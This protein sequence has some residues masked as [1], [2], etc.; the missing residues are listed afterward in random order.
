MAEVA[1]LP[2]PIALYLHVPFCATRC[3]YCDFN[4]YAGLEAFFEPYV[5]ALCREIRSAGAARGR[6]PA[7]T[8]FI[9]GGTPTVLPADLL[10][11]ALAACREAF[12]VAAAAEITCE[13][14]P[15]HATALRTAAHAGR[16]ASAKPPCG[17][18]GEKLTQRRQD[19]KMARRTQ[20]SL[21]PFAPLREA[22]RAVF[23]TGAHAGRGASAKPPRGTADEKLTQ[24]RQDAEMARRTQR[25]FAPFAP[26]R[27]A[28]G[29][30]FRTVAHAACAAT[31]G[32]NR[33][34]ASIRARPRPVF[35]T[36]TADQPAFALLRQLGVNR[37]SLGVQ[38]FDDDE[39]R[40]LGRIHTSAEATAAFMAARAAGFTNLN[41]D[42]IFGLPG[43]P[44]A[45]WR[46]TLAHAVR[47]QGEHLSLY[48]L[49]LEEGAPLADRVRRGLSPAPDE[50]L[51]AD[52]YLFAAD[53]LAAHGYVQYEISNWARPSQT[54]LADLHAPASDHRC[55]H[56]LTYW[57]REPY[58]GFGAGA[59]SFETASEAAGA[60]RRWW[61][62][63]AVP[64]YIQRMNT[65]G[66]AEAGHETI[67][68]RLAMGEMM[69]LGL[70]LTAEGVSDAR[71]RERFGVEMAE[72]FGQEIRRLAGRGLL[73]RLPDRVRLTPGGR[74]LGN[75]VFAEFLP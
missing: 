35:R 73:E 62:V 61:N 68:G 65:A 27:E 47:L 39:L 9:G 34:S 15:G 44:P 41:L 2:F 17:T 26:L 29:A 40:W 63:R 42:L 24:R 33:P 43:Q 20:R 38:S 11:Q 8:I 60:D 56:N 1:A 71:F 74:L 6:P 5:A 52:L 54:A 66:S 58:L 55:R 19:A 49:T 12:D 57:H 23:R 46:R 3:H 16:G 14:N 13:A 75:R 25:S 45:T 31:A 69:M 48:G 36:G 32:E 70:R 28:N 53:F 7:S 18:T 67:G 37:L 10:A 22:S 21:A 51:A 50:D 4:T 64:E 59:H 72:V 30:I